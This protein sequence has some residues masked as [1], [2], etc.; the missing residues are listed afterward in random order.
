MPSAT[1]VNL[2]V[3]TNLPPRTITYRWRSDHDDKRDAERAK[4][5][6]LLDEG[7]EVVTIG[8]GNPDDDDKTI[9]G[10]WQPPVYDAGRPR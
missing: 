7:K 3:N 4:T 10:E 2:S 6:P 8:W 5:E 9:E 1:D